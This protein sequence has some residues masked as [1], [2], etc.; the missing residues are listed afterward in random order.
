MIRSFRKKSLKFFFTGPTDTANFNQVLSKHLYDILFY[1][2]TFF[3]ANMSCEHKKRKKSRAFEK[4]Q[5]FVSKNREK[6]RFSSIFW[7]LKLRALMSPPRITKTRKRKVV[8][9]YER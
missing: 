4:K 6:A 3:G 2:L 1:N 7:T 5:Y 8:C 9:N